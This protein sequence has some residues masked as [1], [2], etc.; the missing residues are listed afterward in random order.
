MQARVGRGRRQDAVAIVAV[1]ARGSARV[2]IHKRDSMHAASV[3]FGLVFVTL[4]AIHRLLRDPVIGMLIG[5]VGVTAC[6]GVGLVT[7]C[8]QLLQ[9]HEE[10]YPLPRV[11]R[12]PKVF[13]RMAI[14]ARRVGNLLGAKVRETDKQD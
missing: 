6:A 8:L 14:H 12:L 1:A 11:I 9:V 10:G 7:G 3:T 5:D 4:R 2:S 13:V